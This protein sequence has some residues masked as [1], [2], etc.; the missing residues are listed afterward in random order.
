MKSGDHQIAARR[1]EFRNPLDDV[2]GQ[3]NQPSLGP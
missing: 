2:R 3:G 1:K